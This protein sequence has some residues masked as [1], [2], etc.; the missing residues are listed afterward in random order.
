MKNF[1][2]L[3]FCF[4]SVLAATAQTT[5][6]ISGGLNYS[7][8]SSSFSSSYIGGRASAQ[9]APRIGLTIDHGFQNQFGLHAGLL[10]SGKGFNLDFEQLRDGVGKGEAKFALN[11]IELPLLAYYNV[12]KFQLQ[13]GAYAAF[14]IN[15]RSTTVFE[16]LE[17]GEPRKLVSEQSLIFSNTRTTDDNL[18]IPIRF[19]RRDLGFMAGVAYQLSETSKLSFQYSKGLT[20]AISDELDNANPVLH[21]AAYSLSLSFAIKKANHR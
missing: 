2:I 21:N 14:A 16:Y 8:G 20:N 17:S 12:N 4:F 18:L 7:S 5:V 9:F 10:Y 11:Y 19:R 13:L 15:G 1:I 3:F 6:N